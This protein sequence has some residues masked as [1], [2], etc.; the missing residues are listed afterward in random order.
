MDKQQKLGLIKQIKEHLKFKIE[1]FIKTNHLINNPKI[2]LIG[3]S[4]IEYLDIS[5]YLFNHQSI[6][7]HGISGLT[8]KE[9]YNNLDSILNDLKISQIFLSIG[10]NDKIVDNIEIDNTLYYIE[11]ILKEL[12]NKYPNI[13]KT[14]ISL[15]PIIAKDNKLYNTPYLFGRIK[16]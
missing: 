7:N 8:S 3:D 9:L 12:N 10:A 13:N 5:K 4:M 2:I 15:T 6:L 14:F 1:N 16:E 11:L